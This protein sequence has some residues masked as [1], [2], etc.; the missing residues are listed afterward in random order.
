MQYEIEKHPDF[1]VADFIGLTVTT[2][3]EKLATFNIFG[4][5]LVFKL[6]NMH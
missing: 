3:Y 2:N 1:G 5:V 4:I 6:F